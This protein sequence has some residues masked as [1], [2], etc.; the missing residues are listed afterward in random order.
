MCRIFGLHDRV[1]REAAELHG[2]HDMH[3]LVGCAGNDN[4]IQHRGPGEYQHPAARSLYVQIEYGQQWCA[5]TTWRLPYLAFIK[6]STDR[7][8]DQAEDENHWQDQVR[9][10]PD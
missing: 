1:T 8:Q 9:Q 2:L 5:F 6:D 7:N 10:Y 3:A 4:D